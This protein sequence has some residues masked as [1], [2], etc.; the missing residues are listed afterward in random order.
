MAARNKLHQKQ[1]VDFFHVSQD[2]FPPHTAKYDRRQYI[3]GG[4]KESALDRS[5]ADVDRPYLHHYR[6]PR[7]MLRPEVWADDMHEPDRPW[8]ID[9]VHRLADDPGP[10]LWEDVPADPDSVKPGE[11]TQYRNHHEDKGSISYIIHKQDARNGGPI[12]YVGVTKLFEPHDSEDDD[13][14]R[15][16]IVWRSFQ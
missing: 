5:E 12:S 7:S 1:F 9:N 2:A 13:N 15:K 3:F 11:V 10:T 14:E 8:S 6:I 4:T 16:P